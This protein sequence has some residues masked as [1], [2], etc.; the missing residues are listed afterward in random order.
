M[1]RQQTLK[2]ASRDALAQHIKRMSNVCCRLKKDRYI[3]RYSG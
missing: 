2:P 1:T 3:R